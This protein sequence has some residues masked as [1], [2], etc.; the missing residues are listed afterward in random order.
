MADNR[1]L[2]FGKFEI[3]PLERQLLVDGQPVTV[4]SRAFDLLLALAERPGQLL[5]KNALLDIVW[6]GVFVEENNLQVQISTLRKCLGPDVIT[7]IPGRGY[8]FTAQR[9]RSFR[10]SADREC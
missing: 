7:T 6:P 4:G 9:L 5:A 3:R 1:P 10:F 8:R 2:C